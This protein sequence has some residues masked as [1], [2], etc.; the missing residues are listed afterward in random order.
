MTGIDWSAAAMAAT[1]L[2]EVADQVRRAEDQLQA[3]QQA[4]R[5]MVLEA[6]AAGMGAT[7]IAELAGL[8]RGAIY[9]IRDSAEN[10]R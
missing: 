10:A 4:R 9:Q 6:I 5:A 8:S 1:G 3:A 7:Q 2:A